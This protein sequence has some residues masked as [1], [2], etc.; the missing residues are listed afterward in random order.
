MHTH[1]IDLI[2][3]SMSKKVKN[4]IIDQLKNFKWAWVNYTKP[5]KELAKAVENVIHKDTNILVL[6]NHGLV[7]GAGTAIQAEKLK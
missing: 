1:P 4:K 5:G 7:V 2:S 6:Q 3:L